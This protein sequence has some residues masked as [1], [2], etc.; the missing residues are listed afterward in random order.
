MVQ[1]LFNNRSGPHIAYQQ[2][3]LRRNHLYYFQRKFTHTVL[4]LHVPQGRPDISAR[5][6]E[7]EYLNLSRKHLGMVRLV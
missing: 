3:T 1:I 6:Q 4:E 2:P 5:V 7:T